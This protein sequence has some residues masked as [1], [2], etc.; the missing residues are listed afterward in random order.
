M[1][2]WNSIKKAPTATKTKTNSI[3]RERMY[4]MCH[5]QI[6]FVH[7]LECTRAKFPIT[8]TFTDSLEIFGMFG[9][10]TIHNYNPYMY[11]V[12]KRAFFFY[13]ILCCLCFCFSFFHFRLATLYLSINKPVFLLL[14]YIHHCIH[15]LSIYNFQ[16][17]ILHTIDYSTCYN[18]LDSHMERIVLFTKRVV[19]FLY[20]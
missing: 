14:H 10:S 5:L 12:S 7:S 17:Y 6:A 16:I 13:L 19:I 8:F 3:L 2:M 20:R 1:F 15:L 11:R 9:N 4:Y 18:R